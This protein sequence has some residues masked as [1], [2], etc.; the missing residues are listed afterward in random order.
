MI[1]VSPESEKVMDTMFKRSSELVVSNEAR[2]PARQL[3]ATERLLG[4][5][6][7]TTVSDNVEGGRPSFLVRLEL[8]KFGPSREYT[9]SRN[10]LGTNLVVPVE[11][12]DLPAVIRL[13]GRRLLLTQPSPR[14]SVEN[15]RLEAE[16]SRL[17]EEL[18]QALERLDVLHT[19]YLTLVEES[20]RID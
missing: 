5:E 4:V 17:Q 9:T 3:V 8:T 20:R 11:E 18:R 19:N 2:G 14:L 15:E 16:V 13:T 6:S 12:R 10:Q 1:L 7:A